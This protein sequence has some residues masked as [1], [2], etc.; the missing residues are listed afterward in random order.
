VSA[1]D[2]PDPPRSDP[3]ELLALP[4]LQAV[5]RLA[6]PTT[7]VMLI[8]TATNVFYTWYVSR[9]GAE[10]LAAVSLVFPVS[11]LVTT[12]MTGGLGGGVASAVAR[13]LGADRRRHATAVAE[14]AVALAVGLG[15]A[16]GLA[17]LAG[18]PA[19]FRLM[20]G[21]DAVLDAAVLFA[22][23]VFGGAV[24]GFLGA[25]LDSVLRGEGNVRVP[26][27][28]SSVSLAL[29]ILL[30]PL[31]MFSAGMGLAGAGVAVVVAQAIAL[32]PR[33]RYVFAGG[34]LLRPRIWPR[35]LRA[36]PLREILRVGVPAS[37]STIVNYLGLVVLTSVIARL[38][39]AHLAAYG[40]CTRF[41]FLLMSFAYGFA[42]AVL[43]LVGLATGARRPER[44]GVYVRHAGACIVALVSAPALLLWWRPDLWMGVFSSEP[45]VHAVGASYFRIVGPTYPF[46]A[47]SMVLAFAFQGLGRATVP[48]AWMVVRVSGVL[49]AAVVCTRWLGLGERAVFA[50]VAVANVAS[51]LLMLPLYRRT[52][53]G[54]TRREAFAAPRPASASR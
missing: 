38:G 18:G 7:F 35:P 2:R 50:A 28:W 48:L 49:A 42:A 51:A 44:A 11:L 31:C 21:R 9:L 14:H 41:D 19:L 46:V 26:S 40:L 16:L 12:A 33:A 23:V 22:R 13:A 25:M 37:L 54:L 15:A 17:M 39:T 47:V 29:Q 24:T 45:A 4:P 43:T 6:T 10:A 8:G 30:T 5:L 27:V 52:V 32:V 36:E 1:S 53:R 34:S 20:G 3:L